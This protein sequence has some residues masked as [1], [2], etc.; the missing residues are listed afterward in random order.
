MFIETDSSYNKTRLPTGK[1]AGLPHI[2]PK[3]L[4]I[5]W[6]IIKINPT[7]LQ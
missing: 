1:F 5:N 4:T 2:Y 7:L 3:L 6:K